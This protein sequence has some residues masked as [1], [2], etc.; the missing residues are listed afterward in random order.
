MVIKRRVQLV[1]PR[2]LVDKPILW[3]LG[4]KFQVVTNIRRANVDSECGW[5][6]VELEGEEEEI[7]RGIRWLQETG[8]E[9]NPI[10][11]QVI[12]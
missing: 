3:Q 1:Y 12:E 11:R 8:I 10:E 9:V 2:H 4:H 6:D 7:E 5:I